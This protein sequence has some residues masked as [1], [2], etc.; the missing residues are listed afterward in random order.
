MKKQEK[1]GS[2]SPVKPALRVESEERATR[3]GSKAE[4]EIR[5]PPEK[6]PCDEGGGKK[7]RRLS[8]TSDSSRETFERYVIFNFSF[9]YY[10]YYCK[11]VISGLCDKYRLF[12]Y[13]AFL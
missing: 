3:S 2:L 11:S 4:K 1:P 13:D 12:R 10:Q 5:L 8:K 7:E 6:S 9:S